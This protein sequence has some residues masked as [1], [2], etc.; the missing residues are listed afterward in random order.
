MKNENMR[1]LIKILQYYTIEEKEN[2]KLE[3]TYQAKKYYKKET[4]RSDFHNVIEIYSILYPEKFK[5]NMLN[6]ISIIV[7]DIWNDICC[8]E[9]ILK[10]ILDRLSE[11]VITL[12][13]DHSSILFEGTKENFDKWSETFDFSEMAVTLSSSYIGNYCETYKKANEALK[14]AKNIRDRFSNNK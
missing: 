14:K 1:N 3:V 2:N 5:D 12:H 10:E 8:N 11:W 4:I 6:S 9:K 7:N 13:N